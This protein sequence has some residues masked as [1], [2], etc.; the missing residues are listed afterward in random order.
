MFDYKQNQKALE[1][2]KSNSLA[3]EF[4]LTTFL[5]DLVKYL[6]IYVIIFPIMF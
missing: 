3:Q 5:Y 4:F 6:L 1:I 2:F